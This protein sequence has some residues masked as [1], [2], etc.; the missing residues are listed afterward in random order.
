MSPWI[1]VCP[2]VQFAGQWVREWLWDRAGL[3]AQLC[4]HLCVC[5]CYGRVS[6][7]PQAGSLCVFALC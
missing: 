7:C 2:C 6:M 5:V 4:V 3:C 1:C